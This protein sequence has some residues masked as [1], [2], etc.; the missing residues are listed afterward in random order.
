MG[1]FEEEDDDDMNLGMW[2]WRESGI[3][4]EEDDDDNTWMWMS[5]INCMALQVEGVSRCSC[6]FSFEKDSS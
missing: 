5:D 1:I 2:V 3:F 4:E 6:F